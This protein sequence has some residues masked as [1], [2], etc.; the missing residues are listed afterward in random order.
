MTSEVSGNRSECV[1]KN[2][3][4][5]KDIAT[6]SQSTCSST[7]HLKITGWYLFVDRGDGLQIWRIAANI[8]RWSSSFMVGRGANNS[9]L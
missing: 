4:W 2:S 7:R 9:S 3:T 1:E 6:F 5:I 8:L